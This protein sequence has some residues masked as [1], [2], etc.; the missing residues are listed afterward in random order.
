MSEISVTLP[1]GSQQRVLARRPVLGGGDEARRKGS[2]QVSRASGGKGPP[3]VWSQKAESH[4][5][6]L[7]ARAAE[8]EADGFDT[9]A[10]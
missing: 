3:T 4:A 8:P 10:T 9:M 7:Y 6:G 1:D 2:K 5:S